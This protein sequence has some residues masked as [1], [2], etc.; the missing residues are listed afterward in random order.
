MSIANRVAPIPLSFNI[1]RLIEHNWVEPQAD[2]RRGLP[3]SQETPR[4]RHPHHPALAATPP[5]GA[6]AG[7]LHPMQFS[8][9]CMKID[10]SWRDTIAYA[11]RE[12]GHRAALVEGGFLLR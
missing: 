12:L 7:M 10:I 3:A 1:S 4:S 6:I 2:P 9:I 5:I 11:A 8:P